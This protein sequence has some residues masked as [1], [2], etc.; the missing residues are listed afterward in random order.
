MNISIPILI[1][2]H[3]HKRK[4]GLTS[5]IENV[6]PYFQK[7][8]KVY[9]FGDLIEGERISWKQLF[10]FTLG[11][12]N[13][14][15]HAHRNNEIIR[16]LFLRL[17]GGKFRLIATRHAETK[18][19]RFTLYLLKQVDQVVTLTSRMQKSLPFSS[20]VVGHGVDTDFYVPNADAKIEGVNQDNVICVAGRIREQKGH[21]VV[22]EALIPI[23]KN[24]KNWALVIVG[25]VDDQDFFKSLNE[26]ISEA[27]L[28]HQV[29]FFPETKNIKK[30][31]QASK[32]VIVPSFSEGFSLVCLE[33]MSCGSTII[34]TAGVGV[35]SDVIRD[36]FTGHLFSA[37]GIIEL[38]KVI[39]EIIVGTRKYT[40][41]SGRLE[42]IENWSAQKEANELKMLY[43]H[44]N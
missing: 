14:I 44:Q 16:A 4:T 40:S 8:F 7:D 17:I 29:Y 2:F 19:S 27:G 12:N 32:V 23:L 13:V 35:H 26:M 11:D 15:I 37:G 31:Y 18:P 28:G 39:S 42:I 41:E 10:K 25:K 43:L 1:Q 21:K 6:M 3:F 34:A 24:Q 33:A 9:V 30:Y 20:A 5:S 22:L 38:R 36:G